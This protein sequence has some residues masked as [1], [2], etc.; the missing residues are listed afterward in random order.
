LDEDEANVSIESG[1]VIEGRLPP[2]A[3]RLV[4]EWTALNREQLLDNWNRARRSEP[5]ERIPG[6]DDDKGD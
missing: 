5:L 4:R 3:A 1:E 2:A 6:L